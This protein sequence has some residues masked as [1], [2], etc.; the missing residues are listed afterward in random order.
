MTRSSPSLHHRVAANLGVA[1]LSVIALATAAGRADADPPSDPATELRFTVNET[2]CGADGVIDF[3]V[4][5]TLVASHGSERACDCGSSEYT[6][7]ISDAAA[8]AAIGDPGCVTLRAVRHDTNEAIAYVRAEIARASGT[9]E[10][11]CVMDWLG[12]APGG[13]CAS[14]DLCNGYSGFGN[15]P[16]SFEVGPADI[17]G[18]G[19]NACVDPDVDNDGFANLA[20]NCPAVANP[21]QQDSDGNGTGDA[22]QA[23]VA[24]VP[25][26]GDEGK[27]H[28]VYSGGAIVLQAS[29]SLGGRGEPVALASG[30]WDPGDGTGPQAISVADSRVLELTHTYT[31]AVGQ[32]FTAIVRVVDASGSVYT[33]TFKVQVQARSLATETNMAI[34]RGLWYEHKTIVLAGNLGNWRNNNAVASTASVVQAFEVNGHRASGDPLRDPYVDD[35]A[36]GL[37]YLETHI[38]RVAIAPEGTLDGDSNG[39][40]YGLETDGGEVVYV[41]GQIVD[42]LV[43]SGTRNAVATVGSEAGRTYHDIAQ[44]L[45]DAYAWGQYE[46]GQGGWVYD[47]NSGGG[48]DSSSSAWWGVAARAG[49][50][51]DL[52][53]PA[54]VKQRNLA[55]GIPALQSFDGSG[56]G[57]DGQCGYRSPGG[58][59]THAAACLIMMAADGVD[60]AHPRYLASEQWLH[61]TWQQQ[62]QGAGSHGRIYAMYNLTKAM[63]LAPGGPITLLGGDIDWYGN[64]PNA[65][66][67]DPNASYTDPAN[68]LARYLIGWQQGNGEF[69][70]GGWVDG[71]TSTAWAVLILSPALFE[72]G[73]TAVCSVD[74]S[75][76]CRAGAAGG[77][78]TTGTDPYATLNLDGS[79]ST[80]GDNPIAGYAWNFQDGS[81]LDVN[82][83]T[84]HR[85]TAVGSYAIQLTVRDTKGISSSVTC[86]VEVTESALPPLADPGGPYA[87]CEG[88]GTVVLDGSH[89]TGRGAN[90]VSYQW[91]FTPAVNF[92]PADAATATTDQ[93]AYFRALPAGTYDVGL[94]VTDDSA[95]HFT[96][97]SFTTVTVIAHADEACGGADADHDGVPDVTDACPGFDDHAD[98]DGDGRPDA[99]DACA[100]DA[101]NDADHDGICGQV[102]FCPLDPDND[103]DED[104]ICGNVDACPHD[105]GNDAD[106]DGACGNVDPCPLDPLDDVDHDGRCGDVDSCPL[107]PQNDADG[108]GVCGDVDICPLGDDDRDA[109]GDHTPDACDR[110][111]G[112]AANDA[113]GDGLCAPPD[114]C[115][116]VANLDQADLDGDAIG[117]ACDPDGDGDGVVDTDDNC[118]GVSNADQASHDADAAGDACDPDDD[119]DGVADAGDSC[120]TIANADQADLDG[121]GIGDVCDEDIDGDGVVNAA[122]N[123]PAVGN[124]DQV[125]HD[126]DA[127]G[128]ACDGDDDDDGRLD[129]ADNC[130]IVANADQANGDGDGEG[131]ACD[132]DDD[133]DTVAD[134]VDNCPLV[135]N[136]G[137]A[138]TDGDGLGDACD[139]DLDG[140]GVLNAVDNCLATPNPNQSNL[141][142]DGFGDACDGDTDGDG[143]ANGLDNCPTTANADQAN[144]DGDAL[145]NACDPDLDGDGVANGADNCVAV[146]N[147][148]QLNTDGDAL[149]N[150]CDPDDDNDGRVDGA[151][152][153]PLIANATQANFDGD[154]VGDACDGDD[155]N[156]GVVDGTDVCPWTAA[157]AVVDRAAGPTTGCSIAQQ[158]PCAGPRGT[159][160]VWQNHGKYVQCVERAAE[161]FEHRH[162]ISERAEGAITSAAAR[163]NCGKPTG[164]P[165][166][167]DDHDD[168][169]HEHHND[170][171]VDGH[172]HD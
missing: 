130:P 46:D 92:T 89:S 8:L 13:S 16:N 33:D 17:D 65:G 113:D 138:N 42:A 154:A 161:A 135:A 23:A 28:V 163:S 96:T 27:P 2:N 57:A 156:D 159:N 136:P 97:T 31:A 160:L 91:D 67:P 60:R 171:D 50:V 12:N 145:G 35:V 15:G 76:V 143:I 30:T 98:A 164:R 102:D 129:G 167:S 169:D 25:W 100:L 103:L 162:L 79:Q 139:P 7:V 104:T 150:A 44:D 1:V 105:P 3:Y 73:P 52:T 40:G 122:D 41:G 86:P 151:D 125:N 56:Q 38:R 133:N 88:T 109:D 9:T 21:A 149:G 18:D 39:N 116:T 101:Q 148:N 51:W 54:F 158:C 152:N 64:D 10:S 128:D 48:I 47:W 108:D 53:V 5:A 26:A 32:P 36:R 93:T 114:N 131:D 68:G 166:K 69:P 118:P 115:P 19:L 24:A 14:R 170:D 147:A 55:Q 141:D 132:G 71:S 6:V 49:E 95:S 157:G 82:V 153:C 70:G 120:P 127:A 144:L 78:N 59:V 111:P 126:A 168:Q 90:I 117:D 146:A 11:I 155:D 45:L 134:G 29:A 66:D 58:D 84:S 165:H 106:H 124:T 37:R 107:D 142:G 81:P 85:F 123:C 63:R 61:R 75:V 99:C 4:G 87:I 137:Q 110:C 121:D 112:D 80:A 62:Q 172:C 74:A 43:A 34:D 22:C 140:D 83:A 94:R 119:N 77:C 72:Q 20:D